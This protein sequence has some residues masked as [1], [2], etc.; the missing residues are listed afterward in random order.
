MPNRNTKEID[1]ELSV[2]VPCFNSSNSL[3]ELVTRCSEVLQN[4]LPIAFEIILVDDCSPDPNT[5]E[6]ISDLSIKHQFVHGVQL[7]LNSGKAGAELCGMGESVGNWVVTIDDDLQILPED[8]PKLFE[9]RNHDVVVGRYKKRRHGFI[10][11]FLSSFRKYFDLVTIKKPLNVPMTPFKL[12]KREVVEEML[13]IRTPYPYIPA[14]IF[15]V[16]RDVGS[17][18]ID[19]QKRFEGGSNFTLKKKVSL[20]SNLLINN[21]SLLLRCVAVCGLIFSCFSLVYAMWLIARYISN[22][23]PVQGWTSTMVLL[24]LIGG[25]IMLAIGIVGEYL[26]RI[27]SGIENRG[28]FIVRKRT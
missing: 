22:D 19:H 16:T 20:F 27:I 26:I 5:W 13:K 1:V 11:K 21:S 24:A 2:V 28:S 18:S 3:Y 17:V 10:S 9:K 12:F 25:V 8:I 23:A 14:L 6:T 7:M 4:E 15:K